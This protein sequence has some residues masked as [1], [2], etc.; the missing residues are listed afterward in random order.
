MYIEETPLTGLCII[1]PEIVKDNRGTFM[2][3]YRKDLFAEKSIP[4]TIVQQNQSSSVKDVIRGL[5]FQWDP[6]LGKLIRV[7]RGKAFMVAADIRKKSSTFGK[8]YGMEFKG[9]EGLAMW[10]PPGFATG[11]CVTGDIAEVEY[12][13]TAIY[14]PE[15]ESNIVWNDPDI[16]IVWPTKNPILSPRDSSAQTLKEWTLRSESDLF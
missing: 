15:G 9:E 4:V 16:G 8:W 12:L 13:Y 1:K 5:H 11:F 10:A 14:N 7:V 6:I 2:Q 3:L